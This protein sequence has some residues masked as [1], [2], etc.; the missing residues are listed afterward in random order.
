ML[1][2]GDLLK[3]RSLQGSQSKSDKDFGGCTESDM[4]DST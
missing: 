1:G 3:S 4:T 2:V